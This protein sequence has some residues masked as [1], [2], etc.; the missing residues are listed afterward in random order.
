MH[1]SFGD[2]CSGV[3]NFIGGGGGGGRSGVFDR[4]H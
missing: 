4:Q 2:G 1:F 3:K